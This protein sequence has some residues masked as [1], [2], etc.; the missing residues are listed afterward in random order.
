MRSSVLS[1]LL[2]ALP[3]G[4]SACSS[5][6]S[7]PAT[8]GN[9]GGGAGGIGGGAGGGGV[10]GS[11]AGTGGGAGAPSIPSPLA[12]YSFDEPGSVLVD[13]V[14]S[15]D[16]ALDGSS[17]AAGRVGGARSFDG[18]SNFAQIDNLPHLGVMTI[19][20]WI[21]VGALPGQDVAVFDRWAWSTNQRSFYLGVTN[22]QA[23]ARIMAQGSWTGAGAGN[24]KLLD[25]A[26]PTNGWAH[27]AATWDATA[28]VFYRDGKSVGSLPTQ[29]ELFDASAVPTLIARSR[30]EPPAYLNVTIDELAVWP[31]AL[32]PEQVAL[33]HARGAAGKPLIGG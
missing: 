22:A 16:G 6:T 17:A 8:G 4:Q 32:S 13:A 2:L 9:A 28:L 21:R 25:L 15:H 7:N 24:P 33:V 27:Y 11:L 30:H 14:G 20:V 3:L 26:A 18:V 10:A 12:Y 23:D 29:G 5:S 19:S 31:S 1:L